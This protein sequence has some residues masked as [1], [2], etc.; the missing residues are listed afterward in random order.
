MTKRE[1]NKIGY[2]IIAAAIEVHKEI[3]PSLL[4]SVYQL[5]LVQELKSRGY[6]VE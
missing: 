5:C 4:E 1:I 2:D 6:L 3:G